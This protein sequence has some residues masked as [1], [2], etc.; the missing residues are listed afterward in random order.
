MIGRALLLNN[1]RFSSINVQDKEIPSNQV[2][3]LLVF[4]AA[5]M[6]EAIQKKLAAHVLSGG[7]L[8]L[9]G[10]VPE[11]DMEG[12]ECTILADFLKIKSM[13]MRED[14]N[15]V[16]LSLTMQ[17]MFQEYAEVRTGYAQSY[18]LE[19]AS[20]VQTLMTVTGT[21]EITAFLREYPVGKAAVLGTDYIC[22]LEAYRRLLE[23]LGTTKGLGSTSS[24]NGLF[25]SMMKGEK[26]ER[27]LHIL[28]L[29]DFDKRSRVIYQGEELFEGQE[30][31]IQ[32]QDGLMLPLNMELDGKFIEYSTAELFERKPEQWTLRLTQLQDVIKLN[33]TY[34]VEESGDYYA[35]YRNDSTYIYSKLDCKRNSFVTV[36]WKRG[37]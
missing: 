3:T 7:S 35:E 17:N 26:E 1:Y 13:K 20:A 31:E 34:E 4:S 28:N 33:G 6:S 16:N 36:N 5:Y 24:Y 19:E 37:E 21:D 23:Y 32:S 18:E 12:R 25:L 8:L 27:L 9:A 29:D 30:I 2:H 14:G 15:P 10:R 22:N 11:Y